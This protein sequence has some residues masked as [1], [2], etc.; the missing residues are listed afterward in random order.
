[1][2][3]KKIVLA[4]SFVAILFLVLALL[5][6]LEKLPNP[7]SIDTTGQP[8]VGTGKIECVV[9]E[10]FCCTNCRTFTEKVF[11]KI[12][13][14]YVDTGKARLT[15]I[16]VSFSDDSKPLAN[17][18]IAVYFLAQDRFI[19]F[20]LEMLRSRVETH[21]EILGAAKTVGGVDLVGLSLKMEQNFYYDVIDQ[22]L[23]WAQKIMG[24]EFGTPTLLINGMETSTASFSKVSHR[25]RQIERAKK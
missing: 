5:H 10:D 9:F 18:A 14:E 2:R 8:S 7:I 17:A 20:I 13:S 24:S 15:L 3:R 12:A 23:V 6:Q 21:A 1:M 22:N 19:P 16:P 11:P 4:T 25:I